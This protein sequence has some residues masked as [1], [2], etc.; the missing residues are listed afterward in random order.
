[1]T[2]S[3]LLPVDGFDLDEIRTGFSSLESILE[4]GEITKPPQGTF[5]ALHSQGTQLHEPISAS[6]LGNRFDDVGFEMS[7]SSS[8]SQAL[9]RRSRSSSAVPGVPMS[10]F[11]RLVTLDICIRLLT[12][13]GSRAFSPCTF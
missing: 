12:G 7:R 4:T 10:P 9:E 6:W 1:M 3:G 13:D 5:T 8:P 11:Y 2:K